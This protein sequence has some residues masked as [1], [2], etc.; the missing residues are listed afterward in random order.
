MTY[1]MDYSGHRLRN[2]MGTYYMN[3]REYSIDI[4]YTV[5]YY[6]IT[7][8]SGLFFTMSIACYDSNELIGVVASDVSLIELFQ[9]LP[10]FRYGKYSYA[11]LIDKQGRLLIHPKQAYAT[12]TNPMPSILQLET[13]EPEFIQVAG[14][15]TI[16]DGEGGEISVFAPLYLANGKDPA[17]GSQVL[18][19]NLTYVWRPIPKSPFIVV[20]VFPIEDYVQ[21]KAQN[22]YWQ[23]FDEPA[24]YH[25]LDNE[26]IANGIN[27]CLLNTIALSPNNSTVKL[28]PG[29]F[30]LP[31]SYIVYGE[32]ERLKLNIQQYLN[33]NATNNTNT[34]INSDVKPDVITT[35]HIIPTWLKNKKYSEENGVIFRYMAT[36]SGVFRIFPGVEANMEYDPRLDSWYHRSLKS[37]SKITV[38]SPFSENDKAWNGYVTV[39]K[40]IYQGRKDHYHP[41]KGEVPVGVAGMDV[42]FGHFRNVLITGAPQCV[43]SD[44]DCYILDKLGYIIADF[45]NKAAQKKEHISQKFP[46][47]TAYLVSKSSVLEGT[48]C[49]DF[50]HDKAHLFYSLKNF[51]IINPDVSNPCYSFALASVPYGDFYLLVRPQS[52]RSCNFNSPPPEFES[53]C[54][55]NSN[56]TCSNCNGITSICQCPCSCPLGHDPCTLK[57]TS[58]ASVVCPIYLPYKN[59]T[60]NTA[61]RLIN[62]ANQ[63]DR[64]CEIAA[65]EELCLIK[66]S[67]KWCGNQKVPAC[68]TFCLTNTSSS[69]SFCIF[70]ENPLLLDA[71]ER[72]KLRTSVVQSLNAFIGNINPKLIWNIRFTTAGQVFYTILGSDVTPNPGYLTS[73]ISQAINNSQVYINY[74]N[75]KLAHMENICTTGHLKINITF[76]PQ[77]FSEYNQDTVKIEFLRFIEAITRTT[78]Q[79][80]IL[81]RRLESY[82]RGSEKASSFM[83]AVIKSKSKDQIEAEVK[84]LQQAIR[85][86][87]SIDLLTLH[88]S[89]KIHRLYINGNLTE[90]FVPTI[91]VTF[92]MSRNMSNFSMPER[93]EISN[94]VIPLLS[95]L[96]NASVASNVKNLRIVDEG[97]TFTLVGGIINDLYSFRDEEI[98]LEEATK[99]GQIVLNTT[100]EAGIIAQKLY[101]NDGFRVKLIVPSMLLNLTFSHMNMDSNDSRLFSERVIV[102]LE[103]ILQ[104]SLKNRLKDISMVKSHF[105]CQLAGQLI[106]KWYPISQEIEKIRASVNRGLYIQKLD[107]HYAYVVRLFQEFRVIAEYSPFQPLSLHFPRIYFGNFQET[108]MNAISKKLLSIVQ[109]IYN[110]DSINF[111]QDVIYSLDKIKFHLLREV[112]NE[113]SIKIYD[114]SFLSNGVADGKFTHLIDDIPR[115]NALYSDNL[116]QSQ[117]IPRIPMIMQFPSYITKSLDIYESKE[118]ETDIITQ[119]NKILSDNMIN[120][121]LKSN[122]TADGRFDFILRGTGSANL[123]SLQQET[124]TLA[125]S[126]KKKLLIQLPQN[127]TVPV[128]RYYSNRVLKAEYLNSI[129]FSF[130]FT[131]Q[132]LNGINLT[133]ISA[134]Q[135]AIDKK[136]DHVLDNGGTVK[137]N[138]TIMWQN[139]IIFNVYENVHFRNWSDIAKQDLIYGV[140]SKLEI[141]LPSNNCTIIATKLYS[142]AELLAIYVPST[143]ITFALALKVPVMWSN[144]ILFNSIKQAMKTHTGRGLENKLAK[145]SLSGRNATFYVNGLHYYN[146]SFMDTDVEAISLSVENKLTLQLSNNSMTYVTEMIQN[147]TVQASYMKKSVMVLTLPPIYLSSLSTGDKSIVSQRLMESLQQTIGINTKQRMIGGVTI[148]NSNITF[149]LMADIEN[150]AENKKAIEDIKKLVIVGFTIYLPKSNALVRKFYSDDIFQAEHVPRSLIRFELPAANLLDYSQLQQN[151]IKHSIL[152]ELQERFLTNSSAKFTNVTLLN[153]GIT[154]ALYEDIDVEK[155]LFEE[156]SYIGKTVQQGFYLTYLESKKIVR[157]MFVDKAF[158]SE[159]LPSEL[160]LLEFL[161]VAFDNMTASELNQVKTTLFE[162]VNQTIG[163]S[164]IHRI[165]ETAITDNTISFT[166]TEHPFNGDSNV[167]ETLHSDIAK[168]NVKVKSGWYWQLPVYQMTPISG[169]YINGNLTEEYIPPTTESPL[170]QTAFPDN[171]TANNQSSLNNHVVITFS[172]LQMNPILIVVISV[173]VFI[174]LGVGAT[175]VVIMKRREETKYRLLRS[176]ADVAISADDNDDY[177]TPIEVK[178]QILESARKLPPP[179]TEVSNSSYSAPY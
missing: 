165:T 4:Q 162:K 76:K 129:G 21:N 138:S 5:P 157:R 152:L 13:M 46:W 125:Q 174:I 141:D 40:T 65:N 45:N 36:E 171:T 159:Y 55:C 177:V 68:S 132:N 18:F 149:M 127:K 26:S 136:L 120:R 38:S 109:K 100:D 119:M 71:F 167:P 82:L 102:S 123:P 118:M 64:A 155:S 69:G 52:A 153:N 150:D 103:D 72:D 104:T 83:L 16:L 24:N 51:T 148:Y 176:S 112:W 105:G 117:Y 48:Y 170:F 108:R 99:T 116:M 7:L 3:L 15:N 140:K 84:S 154:F 56:K 50:E 59:A 122:L 147:G 37:Y 86:G 22:V 6:D 96:F 70:G 79:S 175:A 134:I 143:P 49:R 2:Q 44:N 81:Q 77:D 151:S 92:Q 80:R 20:G 111:V 53:T 33:S 121:I 133:D 113:G 39:S 166:L 124:N 172:S 43:L 106:Q 110:G 179:P 91:N 90:T 42:T 168:L 173:M 47:L 14:I 30:V 97:V 137:P 161:G 54:S 163:L 8:G 128:Y 61:T 67:C 74:Y 66:S 101:I 34:I 115:L 28:A 93:A 160:V 11:F 95:E 19:K 10:Y 139:Q 25:N 73:N 32:T 27:I 158:W 17:D 12:K 107:N 35:A 58:N 145:F 144:E 142:Q 31:L 75:R 94:Q 29:S 1:L 87:I 178:R 88:K 98:R 164:A 62:T 156:V 78:F 126:I 41:G 89:L 135:L 63:C 169:I 57:T 9:R 60:Y 131:C 146:Q 130:T 23:S 114:L 85:N